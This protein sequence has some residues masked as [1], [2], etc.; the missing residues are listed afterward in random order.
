MQRCE[1]KC[2]KKTPKRYKNFHKKDLG[3]KDAR[4]KRLWLLAYSFEEFFH[5]LASPANS[6]VSLSY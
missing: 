3:K 2:E 4:K 6:I 5:M 1:E